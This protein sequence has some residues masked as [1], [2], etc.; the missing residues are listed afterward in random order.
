MTG[1]VTLVVAVEGPWPGSSESDPHG[2]RDLVSSAR[3]VEQRRAHGHHLGQEDVRRFN[4]AS[5]GIERLARLH[6]RVLASVD[7]EVVRRIDEQT[8][9]GRSGFH[10]PDSAGDWLRTVAAM[11]TEPGRGEAEEAAHYVSEGGLGLVLSPTSSPST[12]HWQRKA[13]PVAR[14]T[15]RAERNPDGAGRLR[16]APPNWHTFA[17]D[18]D[19]TRS[20]T[21]L[22][23]RCANALEQGRPVTVGSGARHEV[24]AE[25]LN[26]AGAAVAEPTD[27]NFLYVDG[28]QPEPFTLRHPRVDVVAR[29]STVRVGLMSM[30]HTTLDLDVEGYWFRNR[31]V[32]TSR[33]FADT[34]AFCA[35]ETE[36]K[37]VALNHAGIDR[38]EI[39]HTGFEAAVIGFYRGVARH[40]TAGQRPVHV[41]P[42]YL[43]DG[44]LHGT[45]WGAA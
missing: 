28:S 32:S 15:V 5:A 23:A 37:L 43:V 33:S 10:A 16:A 31:M 41:Q 42:V 29:G 19:R 4:A 25:V 3:T 45:P 40:L 27:L 30:R 17:A 36:R 2:F 6:G 24:I 14:S 7:A 38:L 12:R 9:R 1:S 34:D 11:L 26:Q 20:A 39:V 44:Y 35:A 21:A 8:P 22:W 13:M 18:A